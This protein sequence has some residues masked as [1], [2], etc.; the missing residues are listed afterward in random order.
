MWEERVRV[1][2]HI[3]KEMNTTQYFCW[4]TPQID[5]TTG[6]HHQCGYDTA[7]QFQK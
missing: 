6:I 3:P 1:L 7:Q 2:P 4:D 5:E